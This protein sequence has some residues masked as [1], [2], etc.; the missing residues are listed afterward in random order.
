MVS[1]S[2]SSP[3]F[4]SRTSTATLLITTRS[5]DHI[6]SPH[7][8]AKVVS[9]DPLAIEWSH[10]F[11]DIGL[12]RDHF[13]RSWCYQCLPVSPMPSTARN[14]S[15]AEWPPTAYS[16]RRTELAGSSLDSFGDRIRELIPIAMA[17]PRQRSMSEGMLAGCNPLLWA[18]V[19]S[20]LRR[21]WP[22]TQKFLAAD[23]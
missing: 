13:R 1:S 22:R 8:T 23:L 6:R 12:T 5:H 16:S 18:E 17:E 9:V 3:S 10:G 20:F 14:H 19:I 2:I 4:V 21:E 11:S 15:S 7:L